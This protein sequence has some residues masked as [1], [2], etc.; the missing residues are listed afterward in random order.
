MEAKG[1]NDDAK[2]QSQHTK[3]SLPKGVP[4]KFSARVTVAT[5]ASSGASLPPSVYSEDFFDETSSEIASAWDGDSTV[6]GSE[7]QG[8]YGL[9]GSVWHLAYLACSLGLD[10]DSSHIDSMSQTTL[11]DRNRVPEDTAQTTVVRPAQPEEVEENL[12]QDDI[13]KSR[14][15]YHDLEIC[16]T[17]KIRCKTMCSDFAEHMK[18]NGL[19]PRHFQLKGGPSNVYTL[20]RGELIFRF[21]M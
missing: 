11:F 5:L 16:P 9:N 18:K 2:A 19:N 1:G 17:H 10:V 13:T 15:V 7:S 4:L 20:Q 14:K 3:P 12:W 21:I 6:I 8:E